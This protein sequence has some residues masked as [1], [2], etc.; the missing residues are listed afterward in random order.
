MPSLLRIPWISRGWSPAPKN[1]WFSWTCV[2]LFGSSKSHFSFPSGAVVKNLPANAG[3]AGDVGSIPG[4]GRSLWVGTGNALQ[5]SCLENPMN[6]GTWWATI[7]GIAK[8]RTQLIIYACTQI[9]FHRELQNWDYVLHHC[10]M[11]ESEIH[12]H[13]RVKK[14]GKIKHFWI[15]ERNKIWKFSI[16]KLFIIYKIIII[17]VICGFKI[18]MK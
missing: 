15:S 4:L 6:R 10:I 3:G 17:I 2:Y 13:W 7:H 18:H 1:S 14:E 5:Y 8:N 16:S 12:F 9:T 11:Y